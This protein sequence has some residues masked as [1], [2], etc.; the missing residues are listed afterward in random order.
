M[1][2]YETLGVSKDA[3]PEEIKR[4]YR[5]KSRDNHP[6]RHGPSKTEAFAAITT[7]YSVLSD[8]AKRAEYDATG[9]NDMG[10]EARMRD[11]LCRLLFQC[12]ADVEQANDEGA[13]FDT[14]FAHMQNERV[15][16]MA[17]C[18][19]LKQLIPKRKRLA[20]R[21]RRKR[22]GENI[23]ASVVLNDIAVREKELRA[24]Q[25]AIRDIDE[26]CN[27]IRE[28]EV[29]GD[30]GDIVMQAYRQYSV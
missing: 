16:G 24:V 14:M 6:D 1:N 25:N 10:R 12:L 3:T 2:H 22:E 27:T 21:I 4:A 26:M 17:R 20:E 18:E 11:A 8:A 15:Q 29:K 5:I 28:Y 19:E 13:L 9:G 23:F 7:A 30:L